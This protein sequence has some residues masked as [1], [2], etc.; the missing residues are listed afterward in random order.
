MA[1]G[2]PKRICILDIETEETKFKSPEK[3][4]L[5]FVGIKV[6]TLHNG[7]YYPHK[8]E[9]Y[10]PKQISL[11]FNTENANV[12][13][14]KHKCYPPNQISVLERFLKEFSGIIIGHNILQ[15]DYR[16]LRSLISLE[17]VVEKTV[18]TLAF[19]Y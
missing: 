19:L 13:V 3:S 4:K 7:R 2:L 6:F 12:S 8:H 17:G 18:D 14:H 15:F 9:Y 11:C 10:L 16:V 5:A 1:I